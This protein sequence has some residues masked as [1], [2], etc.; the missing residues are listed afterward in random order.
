VS[1]TCPAGTNRDRGAA[2][3]H[4]RTFLSATL[5]AH[6]LLPLDDR[7]GKPARRRVVVMSL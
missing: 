7:K 4:T 2:V 5:Q 6:L 1:E 3:K